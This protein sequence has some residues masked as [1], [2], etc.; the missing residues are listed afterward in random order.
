M[1]PDYETNLKLIEK[2]QRIAAL[3]AAL[4]IARDYVEDQLVNAS[5]IG[6]K[7]A[8]RKDLKMVEDAIKGE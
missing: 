1:I 3:V 8:A 4:E 2:D 5:T 7:H 6:A